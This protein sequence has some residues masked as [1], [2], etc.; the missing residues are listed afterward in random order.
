MSVKKC[1][2]RADHRV[3]NHD[4]VGR[5]RVLASARESH[6]LDLFRVHLHEWLAFFDGLSITTDH[7]YQLAVLRTDISA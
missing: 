7:Y 4:L 2:A 6:M 5:F 3:R 1:L